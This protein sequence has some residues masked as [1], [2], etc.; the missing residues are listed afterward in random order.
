M[1]DPDFFK[2]DKAEIASAT[3]RLAES[4][5]EL[6]QLMERWEDLDSRA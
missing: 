4:E 2:R 3:D 5:T 6:T 1:A